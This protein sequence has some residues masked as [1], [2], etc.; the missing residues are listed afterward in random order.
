M[1]AAS[2]RVINTNDGER[3]SLG[4]A[5]VIFKIESGATNGACRSAKQP[6]SRVA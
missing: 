6:L 5:D 2:G 4:G 1:Q 3:V